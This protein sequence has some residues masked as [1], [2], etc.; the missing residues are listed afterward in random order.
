MMTAAAV[1]SA[2]VAE[3][4][5]SFRPRRALRDMRWIMWGHSSRRCGVRRMQPADDEP[6]RRVGQRDGEQDYR[7]RAH[8]R[9]PVDDRRQGKDYAACGD[10]VRDE[11]AERDAV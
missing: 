10:G 6:A 7:Q 3:A 1:R 9:E 11:V 2:S 4:S 5:R 8:E